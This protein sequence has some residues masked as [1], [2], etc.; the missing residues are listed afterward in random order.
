[1]G[2][3]SIIL[4]LAL[5]YV[6]PAEWI[7]GVS[8]L[9]LNYIAIGIAIIALINRERGLGLKEIFKTP[10]DTFMAL[11]FLCY[12]WTAPGGNVIAVLGGVY[13]LFV[14]YWVTLLT[15]N[16]I[17]RLLQFLHWWTFFIIFIAALAVASEFGI[18]PTGTFDWTHG[19]QLGRLSLNLSIFNNP[20]ATGHSVA[21]VVAMIYF[22]AFWKRPIFSRVLSP[23]ALVIPLYCIFL[24]SS[25]GAFLSGFATIINAFTF[26]RPLAIQIAIF[27]LAGTMGWAAMQTLPR[28]QELKS[29]RQN[30]GIQG[31]VRAFRMG[32]DIME[33]RIRGSGY[34][35]FVFEFEKRYHY[36]KSAHSSYVGIGTE[37]G[38]PGLYL[39]LGILY[40]CFRTLMSTKTTT[41]DEERVRRVLFVLLISYVVSSWMIGWDNRVIYWLIAAACAAFHR[42]MLEKEQDRLAGETT[43]AASTEIDVQPPPPAS[44]ETPLPALQHQAVTHTELSSLPAAIAPVTSEEAAP[45]PTKP[46]NLFYRTRWY[47]LVAIFFVL[48]ITILFWRYMIKKM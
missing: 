44:L 48:Q 10:H 3:F 18:D 24:T 16:T 12:M 2:Y 31:R 8:M 4:Y 35:T 17:P 32:L 45:T 28:M 6:R 26:K 1:M 27:V 11:F 37:L 20:N 46:A 7:P 13:V 38:K 9:R 40:F 23:L 39:F 36:P 15:L 34:G 41:D 5:Y 29:S 14:F 22:T 33:S 19:R 21:P 42:I 43:T 30:E 25:K 47:D